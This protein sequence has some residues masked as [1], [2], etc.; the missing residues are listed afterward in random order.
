M[1]GVLVRQRTVLAVTLL[2]ATASAVQAAAARWVLANYL[3]A[4]AIN[5]AMLLVSLCTLGYLTTRRA[6]YGGHVFLVFAALV[7]V[8]HFLE[9]GWYLPRFAVTASRIVA[10]YTVNVAQMVAISAAAVFVLR[11]PAHIAIVTAIAPA[12]A[13]AA[14]VHLVTVGRGA[15]LIGIPFGVTTALLI[16][17]ARIALFELDRNRSLV[18]RYLEAA[19]HLQSAVDRALSAERRLVAHSLARSTLHEIGNHL[20]AVCA[21]TVFLRESIDQT[22]LADAEPVVRDIEEGAARTRDVLSRVREMASDHSPAPERVD[23]SSLLARIVASFD[24]DSY[25]ASPVSGEIEPGLSVRAHESDLYTV[26]STLIT[27]V[28]S[29]PRSGGR[30]RVSLARSHGTIVFTCSAVS[31]PDPIA[32]GPDGEPV[33]SGGEELSLVEAILSGYGGELTI[34]AGGAE[35]EVWLG[36]G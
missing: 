3:P 26:F 16:A 27:L 10:Y 29:T 12:Y 11:R 18:S 4:I 13:A 15:L 22:R 31:Q 36:G 28:R 17:V 35:V 33:S 25:G 23:L 21:N 30:A 5:G 34:R 9:L 8:L 1:S 7:C 24:S 6:R 20:N 19:K 2:T 32:S 14:L